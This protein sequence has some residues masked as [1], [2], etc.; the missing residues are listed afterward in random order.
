MSGSITAFDSSGNGRDATMSPGGSKTTVYRTAGLVAGD[1]AV[2]SGGPGVSVSDPWVSIDAFAGGVNASAD[3][4]VI[5]WV[6]APPAYAGLGVTAHIYVSANVLGSGC[7][8]NPIWQDGSVQFGFPSFSAQTWQSVTGILNP[9]GNPHFVAITFTYATQVANLYVDGSLITWT[10]TGSVL[11]NDP[12]LASFYIDIPS[13]G[14][15]CQVTDEFATFRSV[16]SGSDISTL[17]SAGLAG[18]STWNSAVLALSPYAF[19][20]L[21]E[22]APLPTGWHI[23][24]IAMG[25]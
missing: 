10:H 23:G 11:N 6:E 24:E 14:P 13:G 9:D 16:L 15:C 17:Y 8:L 5:C 2:L 21:N 19:Y 1:Y 12:T 18:F 20:H 22:G 3:F 7:E 25:G 4:S